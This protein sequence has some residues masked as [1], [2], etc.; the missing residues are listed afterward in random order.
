MRE[1]RYRRIKR[2]IYKYGNAIMYGVIFTVASII[3]IVAAA[4]RADNIAY[5][6]QS[7]LESSVDAVD[8][9]NSETGK[10]AAKETT[11]EQ[12]TTVEDSAVAVSKVRVTADSLN[13]RKTPST[14]AEPLGEVVMNEEFEV[15]EHVGEWIK[16]KFNG[17]EGYISA[18]FAR[19]VE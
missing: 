5:V 7:Q 15:V 18:A 1:Y 13:V 6:D 8:V 11:S 17:D 4:N 16:I 3:T 9:E 2:N 12:A 19:V 10:V 14:D